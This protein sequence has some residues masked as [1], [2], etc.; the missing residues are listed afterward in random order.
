MT[1]IFKPVSGS[2]QV[3]ALK[4]G[5]IKP[6]PSIIEGE[7]A[8]QKAPTKSFVVQKILG[9]TKGASITEIM[10]AV[11]WQPHSAHAF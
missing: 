10:T 6:A 9:R 7:I 5:A 1:D 3:A 2:T 4:T 11:G 8:K